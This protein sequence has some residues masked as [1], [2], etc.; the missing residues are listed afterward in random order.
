MKTLLGYLTAKV[1]A[2]IIGALF[3]ALAWQTAMIEGFRVWGIGP[4]GW[5]AENAEIAR[6]LKDAR[7]EID[8]LVAESK[9]RKN[10]GREAVAEAER[11]TAPIREQ[12]TRLIPAP[13]DG[14]CT[15]NPAIA[16]SDV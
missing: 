1:S 16:E 6:D 8:E 4:K 12:R 15:T 10:V 9:R 11:R 3:L 14:R 5:R 13:N 2:A 7:A